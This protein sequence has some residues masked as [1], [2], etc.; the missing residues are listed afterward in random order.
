M[1][2]RITNPNGGTAT[3]RTVGLFFSVLGLLLVMHQLGIIWLIVALTRYIA[4][5]LV[6][7]VLVA[8]CCCFQPRLTI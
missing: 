3:E 4:L 2:S 7:F 1:N 5:G 8:D 6:A